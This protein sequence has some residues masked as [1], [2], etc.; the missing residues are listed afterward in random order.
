MDAEVNRLED[1]ITKEF[2]IKKQN[3][4]RQCAYDHANKLD[5]YRRELVS[6]LPWL[7][8][9]ISKRS[10]WGNMLEMVKCMIQDTTIEG[11]M[12]S[13]TMKKDRMEP[14]TGGATP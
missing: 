5:D 2:L 13:R 6:L 8:L 10:D 14:R 11:R 4:I 12:L 9:H 1:K 7:G 3:I